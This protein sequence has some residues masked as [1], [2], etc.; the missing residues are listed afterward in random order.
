MGCRLT[1]KGLIVGGHLAGKWRSHDL[2]T[3]SE[4]HF[5]FETHDPATEDFRTLHGKG[6]LQTYVHVS[7]SPHDEFWVP[8]GADAA[9]AIAELVRTYRAANAAAD[10]S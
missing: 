7:A 3:F 4:A 5:V 9:W 10:A 8:E 1:Y 6:V 2:P